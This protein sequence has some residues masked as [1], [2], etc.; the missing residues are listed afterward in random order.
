MTYASLQMHTLA[1]CDTS[2][3]KPS[4]RT[5]AVNRSYKLIIHEELIPT[6][7]AFSHLAQLGEP[8]KV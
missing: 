7:R 5:H 2:K 8:S 3:P 1:S 4:S 6:V